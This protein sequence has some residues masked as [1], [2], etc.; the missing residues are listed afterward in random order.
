MSSWRDAA[1]QEPPVD[2]EDLALA[3]WESHVEPVHGGDFDEW[4][5]AEQQEPQ[6]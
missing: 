6:P 1:V 5:A 2:V 4:W 3:W